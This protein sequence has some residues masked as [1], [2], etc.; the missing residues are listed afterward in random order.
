[1]GEP[2]PGAWSDRRILAERGPKV[3][4]DPRRPYAWHVE[5]E[6]TADGTV[7]KVAT[8]FL[9][10][11]ECPFRCLMCDL[12]THTTDE[13][14]PAGAIA[15][16]I[17]WALERLPP[18]RHI[19][20]YNAG[21][22]FDERAIPSGDLP[23]VAR[24]LAGFRT[25]LVECH[26]KLVDRRCV[27]FRKMLTPELHVAM[28]LETVHPQALELLNKRMTPG[29]FD[30]AAGFLHGHGIPMRAFLLLRPPLLTEEEGKEWAR[31][32]LTFAFERSV[33]CCVLIPTRPGNGAMDRLMEQ[34][35][36]TPPRMESLEEVTAFGIGL[37]RGRVFADLWDVER[38]YPCPTCGPRRRRRLHD[39]NL[40]QQVQ[41][42][43]TCGC[44]DGS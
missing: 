13:S 38:L 15:G 35:L 40:T 4:L 16:Q 19:K 31:R 28:G 44:R 20:L 14:V 30:R 41:P 2:A 8:V 39:M 17:A 26:P 23:R 37:G 12:W 10:N 18:A 34:G 36:F 6:R 11:R 3:L 27:E 32:S 29:D 25:V 33:E 42:A 22:F 9:T 5:D 7:E 21:N 1:M 43:V 24:L